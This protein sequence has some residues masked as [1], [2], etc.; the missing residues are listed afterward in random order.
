MPERL[1]WRTRI[2]FDRLHLR[3]AFE[4]TAHPAD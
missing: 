2:G 3:P 1:E 4:V